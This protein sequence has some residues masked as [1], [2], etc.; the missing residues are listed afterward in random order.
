MASLKILLYKSN[1]NSDG[2][3]PI[4]LRIIKNRIPKYI[5]I[6][7]IDEK[8]WNAKDRV[9]K[10]SHI[11][12]LQI[13]NKADSKLALA[14]NLITNYESENKEYDLDRLVQRVKGNRVGIGFFRIA[15]EHL[16]YLKKTKKLGTIRSVKY[17][18]QRFRDFTKDENITFEEIN[19]RLLKRF[20][21]YLEEHGY[22][23]TTISSN[24]SFIRNMYNNAIDEDLVKADLYPFGKKSSIKIKNTSTAKIG[25]NTDELKRF[26]NV[27]LEVG[28]K[29]WHTQKVFLFSFYLAGMRIGDVLT[30]KW[31]EIQNGRLYYSMNKNTKYDS[32]QLPKKA[33]EILEH[34]KPL[35][36]R[37]NDVVFPYLKDVNL[38]NIEVLDKKVDNAKSTF[39]YYLKR[40]AKK[41]EI[42]KTISC[43][44]ARHSFGNISGAKIPVQSLQKLYR[45]SDIQ[46]TI[47]Y[48]SNFD[49]SKTDEA[50]NNV[51]DF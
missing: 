12:H 17:H 20:I 44:I 15:D 43:H 26:E 31:S 38:K 37:A 51:L 5:N 10:K 18:V 35:K 23:S 36:K 19:T 29:I 7:W 30:M 6:T 9:V 22:K 28:S 32:L 50:L 39:N 47:N 13:N 25:L 16:S 49:H 45:H 34:Y 27:E 21:A 14:R 24:L 46:T 42:Q 40:I 48:Q 41:A 8:H 2:Q 11:N 4:A 1:K 33:L 3:Y